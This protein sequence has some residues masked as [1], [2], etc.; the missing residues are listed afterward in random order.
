MDREFDEHC[1]VFLK[2]SAGAKRLFQGAEWLEGQRAVRER[3]KCYDNRVCETVEALQTDFDT[4]SLDDAIRQQSKLLYI[5]LLLEHK[6]SELAETFCCSVFWQHVQ[7][8]VRRAR[9]QDFFPYPKARRFC[10]QY[11]HGTPS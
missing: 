5:G 2:C 8:Q 4:T 9:V 7:E 3:I 10:N 6:R 11:G 1:R